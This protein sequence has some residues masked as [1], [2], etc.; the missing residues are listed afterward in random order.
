MT[1]RDELEFQ[2]DESARRE[3]SPEL[4]LPA[5]P[6]ERMDAIPDAQIAHIPPLGDDAHQKLTLELELPTRMDELREAIASLTDVPKLR[7]DALPRVHRLV[8]LGNS[9]QCSR[10]KCPNKAWSNGFGAGVLCLKHTSEI[11]NKSGVPTLFDRNNFVCQTNKMY[12][13]DM[14]NHF[15]ALRAHWRDCP[16]ECKVDS[17]PRLVG[18]PRAP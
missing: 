7:K 4:K 6:D 3:E 9:G 11:F 12:L 10:A 13:E 18:I 1:S 5:P 15:Q 17:C 16:P 2:M 14:V 8:N